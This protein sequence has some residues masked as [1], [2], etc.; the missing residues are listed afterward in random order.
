M[1]KKWS[2]EC[3]ADIKVCRVLLNTGWEYK[4][5]IFVDELY[6]L[7]MLLLEYGLK[8]LI[9]LDQAAVGN[10]LCEGSGNFPMSLINNEIREGEDQECQLFMQSY[11][12]ETK[13]TASASIC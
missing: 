7:L 12:K 3:T 13:M 6:T 10:I 5:S 8:V 4:Y 1:A 2:F 9:G 11:H